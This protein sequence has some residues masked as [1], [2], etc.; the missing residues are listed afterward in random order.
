MTVCA[1]PVAVAEQLA[2]PLPSRIVGVAGTVKIDVAFGKTAVIVSPAPS[3][4]VALEVKPTVQVA[5]A[6]ALSVVDVNVA[7]VG[8]VAAAITTAAPGLT[9]DVLSADVFTLNVLAR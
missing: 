3:A 8:A 9:A 4:P 2:K 6:P 5:R 1:A 7:E